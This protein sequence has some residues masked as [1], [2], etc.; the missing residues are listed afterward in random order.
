MLYWLPRTAASSA[1][2]Y[3]ESLGEVTRWLGG[4]LEPDDRVD[5]PAGC[6]IFPYELQRPTREEAAVRFTDIRHWSEPGHGGH[7]P[8]LELPATFA[9]EVATFFALVR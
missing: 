6:T 2:L 7:F 8:A 1:R 5:A 3:W 9:A 4:P